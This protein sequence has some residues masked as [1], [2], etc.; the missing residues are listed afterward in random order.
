MIDIETLGTSSNAVITSIGATFFDPRTG[1]LGAQFY[2]IVNPQS[3][4]DAGMVMDVS[5]VMWWMRQDDDA[6]KHLFGCVRSEPIGSVLKDF[7]HWVVS[8]SDDIPKLW[9]N[10]CTFDNVIV[11]NAYQKLNMIRP[12]E[13]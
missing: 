12:M 3:R 6:R 7:T 9:G 8:N 1:N 2:T 11:S 10:G 13:I 5:T 4:V